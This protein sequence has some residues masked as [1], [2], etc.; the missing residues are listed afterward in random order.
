MY[1]Y[2]ISYYKMEE[3]V[4]IP[5]SGVDVRLVRPGLGWD[6]GLKLSE[7]IENSGHYVATIDDDA[8]CGMYELWDDLGGSGAVT[9]RCVFIGP[10]DAKAIQAGCVGTNHIAE[11]AVISAKIASG[12]IQ[13]EHIS[14]MAF[15]ASMLSL[16]EQTQ[17]DG[18]G[19]VSSQSP[20]VPGT[21]NEITHVFENEYADTP[22]V[23]F[24]NLCCAHIYISKVDVESSQLTVTL[25]IHDK[26]GVSDFIYK[27]VALSR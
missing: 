4:K 11:G 2:G 7:N 5:H 1:I 14:S 23:L 24:T 8:D 21:D 16:E 13:P 12:A 25:T 9:G 22:I 27:L 15:G 20:A 17:D 10:L 18:I 6:Y 3:G 19:D 26:L